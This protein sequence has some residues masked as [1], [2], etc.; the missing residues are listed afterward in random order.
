MWIK[1]EVQ[2]LRSD[3]GIKP[4]LITESVME[5]QIVYNFARENLTTSQTHCLLDL[6]YGYLL[7]SP[8]MVEIFVAWWSPDPAIVL[9]YL[10]LPPTSTIE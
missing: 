3:T 5:I 6:M 8:S 9:G 7:L 4:S 2:L 1:N 10:I